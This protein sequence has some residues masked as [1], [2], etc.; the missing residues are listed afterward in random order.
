MISPPVKPAPPPPTV[1]T[2]VP[3]SSGLRAWLSSHSPPPPPPLPPS[4]VTVISPPVLPPAVNRKPCTDSNQPT[5]SLGA[6]PVREPDSKVDAGTS[7]L[8]KIAALKDLILKH[9]QS[10]DFDTFQH[11]FEEWTVASRGTVRGHTTRPRHNRGAKRRSVTGGA[12]GVAERSKPKGLNKLRDAFWRDQKKTVRR[13]TEGKEA[14]V[15]CRIPLSTLEERF[16]SDLRT[17]E[18]DESCSELP[19]WMDSENL[20]LNVPAENSYCEVDEPSIT[21]SE[22]DLVLQSLNTASAPGSDRLTYGFWK[23]VDPRG[24]LLARLFEICRSSRRIPERWRSSRVTLI[25]K[26]AKGDLGDVSNWRP[27]SICRTIYKIYTAVLARRLQRWAVDCGAISP[28][29]KGFLPMEGTFEHVFM[30]DA[31]FE[32]AKS[33]KRDLYVVWLDLKNAFGSIDHE[34][35]PAVLNRFG[36]PRYMVEVVTDIYARN[37]CTVLAAA[38]ATGEIPVERGVRQGC[39]LSGIIFDLVA[40]VLIRGVK[41]VKSAGYTFACAPDVKAQVLAYAD[42]GCLISSSRLQTNQQLEVSERFARW[43]T[44]RFN[45]KKCRAMTWMQRGPRRVRDPG[46]FRLSGEEIRVLGHGELY[47]YLGIRSGY[48]DGA[49]ASECVLSETILRVSKLFKS[50]LTPHQKLLALR[51][52]FCPRRFHLADAPICKVQASQVRLPG[53][54]L[55]AGSLR[56][57]EADGES[58]FLHFP[59]FGW[60]GCFVSRLRGRRY[61]SHPSV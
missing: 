29:Q 11:D 45:P 1:A 46:S 50:R 13:I 21:A 27:I 55:H 19:P 44:L 5:V 12:A 9:E 3:S 14:E 36:A 16:R 26:D 41:S 17:P 54:A 20:G 34:C 25:V 24:K 10:S 40:E 35:I 49:A 15:R 48:L 52:S 53:A 61:G 6:R 32:D 57:A 8:Q 2:P 51:D 28:E 7:H 39:P 18:R 30:L 60:L 38:G 43:A 59:R 33:N 56:L 22:V 23:S 58:I 31:A 37:T 47:K 42:D 4:V